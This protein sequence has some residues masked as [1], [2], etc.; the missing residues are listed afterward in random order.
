MSSSAGHFL[1]V[2]DDADLLMV[3]RDLVRHW[4]YTCDTAAE[5]FDGLDLYRAG[6]YDLVILDLELPDVKG[7]NLAREFLKRKPAPPIL[8][9][10]GHGSAERARQLGREGVFQFI[11]KPF[12]TVELHHAVRS[13]LRRWTLIQSGVTADELFELREVA[14]LMR[15]ETTRKE[16][17]QNLLRS[18][19]RLTSASSGSIMLWDPE[20]KCLRVEVAENLPP[21]AVGSCVPM[22]DRISGRVF[23]EGRPR[24]IAGSVEGDPHLS[25]AGGRPEIKSALCVPAFAR[26]VPVGVLN[27][28]SNIS[29]AFFTERDLQVASIFAGDAA[30]FLSHFDL[31]DELRR[32]VT[33]LEQAQASLAQVAE[34]ASMS[35]KTASVATLAGGIAHQFNNLLAIIQS[36][37]E[38]IQMK[39]LPAETGVAKAL[40]AS[41]RAAE[42][43]ADM[44]TFSRTM[45][46][47]DRTLV[48]MPEVIRR[49]AQVTGKEFETAHVLLKTDLGPGAMTVQGAP[50]EIQEI[51]MNLVM[52]AREA[53]E[54]G[55]ELTIGAWLQGNQVLVR[56]RDTGPGIPA[57][58]LKQIF[59]PFYTTKAQG[60][61]LGLWRVYHLAR[62]LGGSVEVESIPGQGTCFTVHLPHAA[63]SR[64]GQHEPTAPA[65]R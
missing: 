43:A 19:V 33:A 29:D 40:E 44:L 36:N 22:G 15:E 6:T 26:G 25:R 4:G 32:K 1:I 48:S 53:M 3:Y 9:V 13:A 7:D 5:G 39:M 61:G 12:D 11:N 46:R 45:R 8:V 10:T 52:N 55:G 58:A 62:N 30:T 16:V 24:L 28:N 51:L 38:M 50:A 23:E 65:R 34:R 54:A 14:L 59:D 31:M 27:L 17:L 20:S 63:A 41:H 47:T 21:E 2:E 37:L 42:V 60:T 57:A 35:E 18:A 56:V 49:I 64:E